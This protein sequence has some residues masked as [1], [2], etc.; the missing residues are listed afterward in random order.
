MNE[1]HVVTGVTTALNA[2]N[3]GTAAAPNWNGAAN[4]IGVQRRDFS[5]DQD[6][7]YFSGGFRWDFDRVHIDF[8]GS[9]AKAH[10]DSQTNLISL[11]TSVSGIV[12]DRNNAQGIPVFQFPSNFDPSDP[13]VYSDFTRTGANG[14]VLPVYGPTVQYR[15]AEYN[16]TEDQLKLDL[17]WEIDHPIISKF[18]F[19]AQ[20]RR[21]KFL[22]YLGGGSILIDPATM[23]YQSSANVSYTTTIQNNPAVARNGNTYFITPAQYGSLISSI[24]GVTGGAPLYTGLKNAP[25]GIPSRLAFPISIPTCCRRS[26]IS[27]AS[28]TT[29]CA[30]QTAIR[31]SRAPRSP[32]RCSRAMR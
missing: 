14:Q 3:L 12:I 16:N 25:S 29:S 17:D 1:N 5:Y 10:T 18:E 27:P 7:K 9:H 6:S 31:R 28:I 11:G 21:Q 32:R 23:T 4:I 15:P 24:G 19:G 20:A 13:G 26:T 22:N 2:V 30:S 8:M